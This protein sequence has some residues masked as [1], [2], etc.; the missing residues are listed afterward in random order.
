MINSILAT[1]EGDALSEQIV[2]FLVENETAMDSAKGIASWWV[3][4]DELAVQAAL[5]RLIA[6][7]V[8]TPHTLSSGTLYGLTRNQGIR[9]W[10]RATYRPPSKLEGRLPGD[11]NRPGA[12]SS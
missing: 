9:H 7:G 6:C 10:L 11:G 12:D 2:Q 8:I 4:H 3:R 5:D 1:L